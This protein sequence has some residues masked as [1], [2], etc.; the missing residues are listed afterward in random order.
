VLEHLVHDADAGGVFGFPGIVS[1]QAGSRYAS[2]SSRTDRNPGKRD[3]CVHLSPLEPPAAR[4]KR[5]PKL[6]FAERAARHAYAEACLA[7]FAAAFFFVYFW[8]NFSHPA[9][10][11]DDL[12]A[13]PCRTGGRTSRLHVQGL[14]Q[15]G[16][17][18]ERVSA[19]AGYGD[20]LVF[21]MDFGFH[22]I[23]LAGAGR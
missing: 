17:G 7:G 22:G 12:F 8:R 19:A 14:C 13:C 23:V 21:G 2:T 18:R 5:Q 6:P 1:D 20:F 16:A 9:G 10:R 11:I 4:K 15:R 3:H